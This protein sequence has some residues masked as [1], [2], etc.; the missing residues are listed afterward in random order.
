MLKALMIVLALA[1]LAAAQLGT[2][3]EA[4]DPVT[5]LSVWENYKAKLSLPCIFDGKLDANGQLVIPLFDALSITSIEVGGKGVSATVGDS[6][7]TLVGSPNLPIRVG[8]K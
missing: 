2:A 6:T 1:T 7:L 3:R 4:R 8:A 5:S